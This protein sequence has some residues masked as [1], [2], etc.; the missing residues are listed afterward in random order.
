MQT[1][2]HV[3]VELFLYAVLFTLWEAGPQNGHVILEMAALEKAI[4][5]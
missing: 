5:T 1:L 3:W 4:N 2:S